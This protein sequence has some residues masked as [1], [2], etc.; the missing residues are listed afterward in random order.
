MLAVF[1]TQRLENFRGQILIYLIDLIRTLDLEL[2][3]L[4]LFDQRQGE[5]KLIDG[6]ASLTADWVCLLV[7]KNP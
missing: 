3:H 4:L 2:K 5:G 1:T 6:P 7:Q